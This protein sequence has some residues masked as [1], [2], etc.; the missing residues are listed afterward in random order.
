MADFGYVNEDAGQLDVLVDEPARTV[1]FSLRPL[2]SALERAKLE[3]G[4]RHTI[5]VLDFNAATL[6]ITPLNTFASEGLFL[7]PKY[8]KIR[9]IVVPFRADKYSLSEFSSD[10]DLASVFDELPRGLSRHYQFGLGLPKDYKMIISTIEKVSDAKTLIFDVETKLDGFNF[11]ISP[12]DFERIRSEIDRIKARANSASLRVREAWVHNAIAEFTGDD[13]VPIKRGRHPHVQQFV[14]EAAGGAVLDESAID[15]LVEAAMSESARIATERPDRLGKLRSDLEMLTLDSLIQSF[16]AA[17]D[18]GKSEPFWQKFFVENPFALHMALGYPVTIVQDQASVGGTR[19]DG[20]GTKVADFL[21][22][23][24]LTNNVAL[25]EI[26]KPRTA[27]VQQRQYRGE[28]HGPSAELTSSIVQVLDQRYR[29]QTKIDSIRSDNRE[30]AIETFAVKAFLIAGTTPEGEAEKKSFEMFRGNSMVVTVVTYD[31]VLAK[32]IQLRDLVRNGE[33][34]DAQDAP[35][36][37]PAD[38]VSDKQ[39]NSRPT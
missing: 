35:D 39:R 4:S 10:A 30:L 12:D 15:A 21:A 19:L 14:D 38:A 22:K 5:A 8:D 33:N 28:V 26:K 6:T 1:T 27:M 31:E 7:A 17:L 2:K 13:Q 20:G 32:L 25:V 37:S 34:G 36:T 9:T 24:P 18:E 16:S 3:P 29:L 11:R 23:N